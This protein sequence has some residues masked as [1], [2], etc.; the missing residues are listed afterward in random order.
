MD[1]NTGLMTV[2]WG[3]HN[4]VL[5][6]QKRVRD[7]PRAARVIFTI[8]NGGKPVGWTGCLIF[9]F[10][11]YMFSG[12]LAL[13]MFSGECTSPLT[14]SIMENLHGEPHGTL[15]VEFF[16]EAALGGA[17]VFV[18]SDDMFIEETSKAPLLRSK[19]LGKLKRPLVRVL[20]SFL[21]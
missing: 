14:T 17:V 19:P 7:I 6:V 18:D 1:K 13:N 10:E 4:S 9:D 16:V 3:I 2:N 5:E 21:F 11:N 12:P 8:K 20:E 15:E